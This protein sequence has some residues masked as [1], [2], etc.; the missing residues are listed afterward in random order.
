MKCFILRWLLKLRYRIEVEGVVPGEEP[1]VVAAL[2]S[3]KLDPLILAAYTTSKKGTPSKR[4]VIVAAPKLCILLRQWIALPLFLDQ[5]SRFFGRRVLRVALPALEKERKKDWIVVV[6]G[7]NNPLLEALRIENRKMFCATIEGMEGS[8]F[9]VGTSREPLKFWKAV[10]LVVRNG[11][12]WMPKRK[13]KL[14]FRE[15]GILYPNRAVSKEVPD[16]FWKKKSQIPELKYEEA[17]L[18]EV[19]RLAKKQSIRKEM[20]LYE[21]LMLDS[22]DVTE[23][24]ITME[25][26]FGCRIPFA[27][28]ETVQDVISAARGISR[29]KPFNQ[30]PSWMKPR[31]AT[32]PPEGKSLGEAFLRSCDR[33]GSSL[34]AADPMGAVSYA[35]L[36]SLS[37]GLREC[38]QK[39]PGKEIGVLMGA[40]TETY[41]LIMAI[42]LAG[43]TPVMLNWS[44]GPL[45]LDEVLEETGIEFIVT[46]AHFLQ[47]L[48]MEL[49]EKIEEK[50]VLLEELNQGVSFEKRQEALKIS[51]QAADELIKRFNLDGLSGDETAVL[52]FTSGTEKMPKGVPLSHLNLLSN[53]RAVFEFVQFTSDDVLMGL[54]PVF[55]VYGFSLTGLF[56]LLIGLKTV[57]HPSP[58]DYQGA[59]KEIERWQVTTVATVP[60]FMRGLLQMADSVQLKSLRRYVVGAEKPPPGLM[61]M[62]PAGAEVIEGYGLTECSPVLTLKRYPDDPGVGKLLRGIDCKIVDPES[63][64][65]IKTGKTGLIMVKGASVFKGY[66]RASGES[67]EWFNTQDIG[68]LDER[69]YLHLEGRESRTAKIGGEMIGL[70]AIETIVAQ[71]FPPAQVAIIAE[72]DPK[73]GSHLVLFTT[74]ELSLEEV[75]H[76]LN[77]AGLS[78]LLKIS[79]IEKVESLPLTPL[80]KI[81]YKRLKKAF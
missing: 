39:M 17:V 46:S 1:F 31:P 9:M 18:A 30:I 61:E 19:S 80:G 15:G 13:V 75:N 78:P 63:F 69:G 6:Q 44:Q 81:D 74:R 59:L 68:F 35:R 16:F 47:H 66:Y 73:K 4:G 77:K 79:M 26:K 14:T 57:Y 25:K 3:S 22:L 32:Q 7:A 11:I 24:I 10:S 71:A 54:L 56:P 58:L 70:P 34:D 37:I 33:L 8:R 55:H 38:V 27:A 64:K 53:Q 5:A 12:F 2:C 43:K 62:I 76:A 20:H 49:S 65:P 40:S 41:C 45:W 48:P 51:R 23:L 21:D 50:M 28:V 42:I 29:Q 67:S 36:K 72:S 60:T 52:L